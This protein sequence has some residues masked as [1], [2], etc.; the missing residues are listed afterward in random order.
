MEVMDVAK[1]SP[2]NA[3]GKRKVRRGSVTGPS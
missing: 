3:K 2:N 1:N